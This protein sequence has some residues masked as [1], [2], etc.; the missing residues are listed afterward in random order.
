MGKC[1]SNL[2]KALQPSKFNYESRFYA[3]RITDN[4]TPV[5]VYTKW[6]SMMSATYIVFADFRL[7]KISKSNREK[8]IDQV[9]SEWLN[10]N[11]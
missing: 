10:N 5:K 7:T 8:F 1:G 3:D 9:S 2:R 6:S 4:F 11:D